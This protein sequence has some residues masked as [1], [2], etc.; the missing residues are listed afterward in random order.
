MVRAEVTTPTDVVPMMPTLALPPGVPSAAE[1]VAGEAIEFVW[2]NVIR[3]APVSDLPG[4]GG[5]RRRGS[6]TAAAS[7]WSR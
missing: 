6:L 1:A 3:R 7:R 5:S 2:V 4:S